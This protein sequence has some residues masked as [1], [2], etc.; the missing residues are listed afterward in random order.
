MLGRLLTAMALLTL[1]LPAALLPGTANAASAPGG[2]AAAGDFVRVCG[3]RL[4]LHGHPFEVRGATAYSH[5]DDPRAEVTLARRAHLN[6]IELVEFDTR[7]HDLSDTM[8]EA[9]WTRVDKVVAAARAAGMHVILH[10]AEYGQSLAANGTTPTTVDWKSYL[11]FV[12][13]RVNT[14]TG[15]TYKN[16]PTIAMVQLY[17][18]IDAPNFGVPTAGT[19]EQMTAFFA[20]TL[21][22]WHELA[23]NIPASSG[24]FSYL[25]YSNSGIDWQTI[26]ADPNNAACGVE[27]N[28]TADRDV[29][30]PNVSSYCKSLGKPWF[31]AAWS[32]CYNHNP[33]GPE[34]LDHFPDDATMAA[35]AREMKLV[36]LG[37][38]ADGP[39][40]AM[41]AIGSDFWNL[42]AG[43]VVEGTCDI[44]PQFP[45]TFAAVREPHPAG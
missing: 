10:F 34:D 20:R 12:A 32:S 33:W 28:S 13:N 35:H 42:G 31:L 9:T 26:M 4:C 11:R 5:Y 18:E 44:G 45:Q 8:S 40:P 29:S 25:N 30:V 19:T 6:V 21:A 41:P 7:Y 43:P 27:V 24:G 36:A 1:S 17:G 38:R 3:T 23:P 16:D 14:V 22:Q 2:T 39:A 37:R 15:V